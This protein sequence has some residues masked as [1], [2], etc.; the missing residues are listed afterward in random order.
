MFKPI[1]STSRSFHNSLRMAC[2]NTEALLQLLQDLLKRLGPFG[3]GTAIYSCYLSPRS[4]WR[5]PAWESD[6]DS[7]QKKTKW[8]QR[9]DTQIKHNYIARWWMIINTRRSYKKTC[10]IGTRWCLNVFSMAA[11]ALQFFSLH[12]GRPH[13][14]Q[15]SLALVNLIPACKIT[16]LSIWKCFQFENVEVFSCNH[17]FFRHK[18]PK[19]YYP[20]P[21]KGAKLRST[22][23]TELLTGLL[24][25]HICGWPRVTGWSHCT[26]CAPWS[27]APSKLAKHLGWLRL[28]RNSWTTLTH[29][30]SKTCRWTIN[31]KLTKW[32]TWLGVA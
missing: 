32:K 9:K 7:P 18:L 20:T 13:P 2:V 5:R 30:Y 8:L 27:S 24:L 25:G 12:F 1:P 28:D 26:D 17:P 4:S 19:L 11:E 14:S 3:N 10:N 15:K 16:I 23:Q 31:N 21:K 6:F 22:Q 29:V